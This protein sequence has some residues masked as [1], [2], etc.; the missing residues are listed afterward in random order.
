MK[1]FSNSLVIF[2]LL[3]SPVIKSQQ[4]EL[5][6]G[7]HILGYA[8]DLQFRD[9]TKPCGGLAVKDVYKGFG[10][11]GSVYAM[12]TKPYGDTTVIHELYEYRT[13]PF[14]SAKYDLTLMPDG[15]TA[16]LTY[17]FKFRL[18]LFAGAGVALERIKHMRYDNFYQPTATGFYTD[19]YSSKYTE[20]I[21]GQKRV[22]FELGVDYDFVA[23]EQWACGVRVGWNS[24]M[25][26]SGQLIV[27]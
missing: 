9:Y 13:Q 15:W 1:V 12:R 3:L 23:A 11:Y 18:S 25:K 22:M 4:V 21:A 2:L 14:D 26:G 6:G 20:N 5:F 8:K 16:G 27:G 10:V 24:V 7:V 17:T 19:L